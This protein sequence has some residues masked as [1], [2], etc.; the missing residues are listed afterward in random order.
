M[1][2]T[3]GHAL[4]MCFRYRYY[5]KHTCWRQS[6]YEAICGVQ[7]RFEL[8]NLP[9][10]WF[11]RCCSLYVGERV[12]IEAVKRAIVCLE[13]LDFVSKNTV[14]R[15]GADC[16][17]IYC[18]LWETVRDIELVLDIAFR[19]IPEFSAAYVTCRSPPIYA[20][21]AEYLVCAGHSCLVLGS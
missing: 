11:L 1:W 8:N 18:R 19:P 20:N 17:I 4:N 12:E 7:C 5:S 15:L 14:L 21:G 10:R 9:L 2:C 13:P 3:V 16:D 6:S